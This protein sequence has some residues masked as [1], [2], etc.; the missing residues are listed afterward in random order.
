MAQPG[1][2]RLPG[3]S[4]G[5]GDF[6]VPH[7]AHEAATNL[8]AATYGQELAEQLVEE[9]TKC[10]WKAIES[11]IGALRRALTTRQMTQHL[12]RTL[13]SFSADALRLVRRW[14][15]PP[16]LTVALCGADG[17]GK[18]TAARGIIEGL[19]GTFSPRKGRSIHWKPPV[20]SGGRRSARGPTSDPHGEPTR[21]AAASLIYFGFHWLE[22]FLGSIL[23]LRPVTFRG[24]LVLID[25]YYYD[26]LWTQGA[27]ASDCRPG[28]C[29]RATRS[30]PIP[31]W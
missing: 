14:L 8:L 31:I 2:S 12:T 21:N 28:S 3:F 16:G 17:S 20:F 30:L 27:T 26:F 23:C 1:F 22:F 4:P 10:E 13:F 24:G 19:S 25:R 6:A 11:R 29:A 15:R 5:R 9:G 18:S 7:P